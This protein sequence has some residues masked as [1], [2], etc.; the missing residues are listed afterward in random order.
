MK[1]STLFPNDIFKMPKLLRNLVNIN[2]S[3]FCFTFEWKLTNAKKINPH[4]ILENKK[5]SRDLFSRINLKDAETY[6]TTWSLEVQSIIS[7]TIQTTYVN[8]ENITHWDAKHKALK[9]Q[10]WSVL[11]SC[12][13]KGDQWRCS[14]IP[15]FVSTQMQTQRIHK[16]NWSC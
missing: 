16:Q 10:H 8:S 9:H 12:L 1:S 14:C 3:L 15:V 6:E 7:N 2:N 4:E 11:W 13:F 5:W